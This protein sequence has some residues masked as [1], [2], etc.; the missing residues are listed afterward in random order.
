MSMKV[1]DVSKQKS[2]NTSYKQNLPTKKYQSNSENKAICESQK[3]FSGKELRTLRARR[4]YAL[5]ISAEEAV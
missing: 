5:L 4:R 1:L 2:N 3:S